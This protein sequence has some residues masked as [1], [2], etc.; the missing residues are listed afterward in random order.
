MSGYNRLA[1]TIG[2]LACLA[3]GAARAQQEFP[4]PQGGTAPVVVVASAGDPAP[5][6]FL[7]PYAGCAIGQEWLEGGEHALS[8]L[9]TQRRLTKQQARER[10]AGVHLGVRQH[11]Q[12]FELLDRQ[13]MRLVQ[14]DRFGAGQ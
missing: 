6:K 7:A 12:L 11:P 2:V 3:A 9:A 8:E 1:A 5:F 10:C 14:D 13:K 4:P